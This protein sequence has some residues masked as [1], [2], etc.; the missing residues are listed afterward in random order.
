MIAR[1][2][3]EFNGCEVGDEMF[4]DA[5][6]TGGSGGELPFDQGPGFTAITPLGLALPFGWLITKVNWVRVTDK[7]IDQTGTG[8]SP[9]G[10]GKATL[11]GFDGLFTPSASRTFDWY[12]SSG[13]EKSNAGW[14]AAAEGGLRVRVVLGEI[15]SFTRFS[16]DIERYFFGARVGIRSTFVSGGPGFRDT[17]LVFEVG[18]GSW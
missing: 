5:I 2:R 4:A 12:I 8:I 11:W 6:A 7:P 17:R 1:D 9:T 16:H 18:G 10:P 14:E 15:L 13:P 3:L